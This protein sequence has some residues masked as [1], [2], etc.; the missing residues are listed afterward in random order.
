MTSKSLA[1]I[2][3]NQLYLSPCY[4]GSA[5]LE[6]IGLWILPCSLLA[7]GHTYNFRT[8]VVLTRNIE[9]SKTNSGIGWK[10][11]IK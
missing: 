1:I 8:I 6:E 7:L 10:P 2:E 3:S 9:S 11:K 4:S 5:C